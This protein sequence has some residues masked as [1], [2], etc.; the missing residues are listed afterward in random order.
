M[1]ATSTASTPS[2]NNTSARIMLQM[3]RLFYDDALVSAMQN[4]YWINGISAL[5]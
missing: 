1:Y 5:A 2:H 3:F 4:Y